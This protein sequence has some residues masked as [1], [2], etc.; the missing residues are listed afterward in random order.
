MKRV[1][2]PYDFGAIHALLV[3]SFAYM[4][5]R[6]DPPSSLH[7]M[8]AATLEQEAREK[9]LWVIEDA[10]RPVACMI[11]I[12]KPDTLYLG[13]LAVDADRRGQG[14]ARRLIEQAETRARRLA[15]P[16]ITLQTRVE[17]TE[18]H[19]TFGKLGFMQ[20]GATAH[21]GYDRPTSLT[22]TKTVAPNAG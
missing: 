13:K 10:G 16:S 14:L 6:I 15:L 19:V 21:A 12:P 7:R 4:A 3:S 17:L 2:P 1:R 20:T 8:T 22:F 18:N 5:G 9:E 11:L